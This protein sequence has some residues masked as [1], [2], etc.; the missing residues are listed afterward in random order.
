MS[1]VT[2]VHNEELP[3][4]A[5]WWA[6]ASR[7]GRVIEP[8]MRDWLQHLPTRAKGLVE[9][10]NVCAPTRK[11]MAIKA[12]VKREK[13]VSKICGK[14]VK[15]SFAPRLIQGRSVSVKVATGPF[16]WA[17]GK[18]LA[19]LY[20]FD[21]N[22]LYT[23]G[24]SAEEVGAFYDKINYMN[25]N[26]DWKW[27]A[28]DCKRWDRSVGP[29][30]LRMLKREYARCGAPRECLL[31]LSDRHGERFGVTQNGIRF[32][33]T[34]QVASGDGDTSAG[35]SRIHLVML[36]ACSD[37]RAAMVSGDDALV[38]TNNIDG[39]CDFYRCGGFTPIVNTNEVDFCSALFY[40]TMDGSVLGPKIGRVLGKTFHSMYKSPNG[41]YMP[42]LRGVCLSMQVSC[43]YIPIL[44]VLVRRLL[45][46]AG[47]GKVKHKQS[48]QYKSLAKYSHEVSEETWSF[49][50]ERYGLYETDILD[51]EAE[52]EKVE[53]GRTYSP[54]LLDIIKRDL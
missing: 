33:R 28:I 29:T 4:W 25:A 39:V 51:I 42:W 41:D 20:N 2:S 37:V 3:I 18:A 34:G 44:R 35:N 40:P 43:S 26:N 49:L 7:M 1:R 32:K 48:Y 12:F 27:F 47:E 36:E 19:K 11:D 8:E 15:E 16:T 23:G 10:A 54:V 31:A 24:L 50:Y 22:Y 38:Y 9:N 46:I 30:Q 17:F 21:G 6:Q 14:A 45:E 53:L 52:L 5:E 13:R